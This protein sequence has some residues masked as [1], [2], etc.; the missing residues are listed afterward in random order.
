MFNLNLYEEGIEVG[1]EKGQYLLLIK[2]LRKKLGTI[3]KNYI[4]K[5]ESLDNKKIITVALNIFNIESI[6]DLDRYLI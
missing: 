1:I 3:S 6:E 2:L 4:N 5:L